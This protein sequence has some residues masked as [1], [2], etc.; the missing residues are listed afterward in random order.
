M[1]TVGIKK[2]ID[3]LLDGLK[4]VGVNAKI[5]TKVLDVP[6]MGAVIDL[7]YEGALRTRVIPPLQ[8][9]LAQTDQDT[10]ICTVTLYAFHEKEKYSETCIIW[11]NASCHI[12]GDRSMEEKRQTADGRVYVTEYAKGQKFPILLKKVA[13]SDEEMKS[14][15][16]EEAFK[17]IKENN[18][19]GI[20]NKPMGAVVLDAVMKVRGVPA[21]PV[22]CEEDTISIPT[23]ANYRGILPIDAPYV[24]WGDGEGNVIPLCEKGFFTTLAEIALGD[25]GVCTRALRKGYEVWVEDNSGKW[26]MPGTKGVVRVKSSVPDSEPSVMSKKTN[27]SNNKGA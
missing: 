11:G 26:F 5:R 27:N 25:K 22:A 7:D 18:K 6:L 21:S 9:I 20:P 23:P 8:R 16:L 15:A 14:K 17:T 24:I 1:V 12:K 2:T 10:G 13:V 19:N 3:A 4:K